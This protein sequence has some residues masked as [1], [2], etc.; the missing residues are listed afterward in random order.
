MRKRGGSPGH[1]SQTIRPVRPRLTRFQQQSERRITFCLHAARLVLYTQY[2]FSG[3]RKCL[4][5]VPTVFA[6]C[7]RVTV[8]GLRQTAYLQGF[9]CGCVV[10]LSGM[11]KP[12]A[13]VPATEAR[14]CSGVWPKCVPRD[15]TSLARSGKGSPRLCPNRLW[16]CRRKVA[17]GH[18]RAVAQLLD[19]M[20][21]FGFEPVICPVP[22]D[23]LLD[24]SLA[25]R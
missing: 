18:P 2:H 13:P 4:F 8:A 3:A 10:C 14:G 24:H 1:K 25:G 15:G 22:V 7:C 21:P 11:N 6:F 17:G 20:R 23:V 19:R 5:G 12:R 16:R 9:C